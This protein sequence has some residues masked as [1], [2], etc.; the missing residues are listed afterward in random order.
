MRVVIILGVLFVI[1]VPLVV[2]GSNNTH[3]YMYGSS[4]CP[5]CRV[6]QSFLDKYFPH[7]TFCDMNTNRTCVE[8]FTRLINITGTP[9]SIPIIVVVDN[10]SIKGI[11]IGEYTNITFWNDMIM[12]KRNGTSSIPI[13]SDGRIIG[14]IPSNRSKYINLI[15]KETVPSPPNT[16]EPILTPIYNTSVMSTT[17]NHNSILGKGVILFLLTAILYTILVETEPWKRR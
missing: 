12:S 5:H 13:Y 14:Y 11:I 17:G 8:L 6:M 4:T 3:I 16:E 7:Y 2:Y 10:N 1:L 15:L 9:P